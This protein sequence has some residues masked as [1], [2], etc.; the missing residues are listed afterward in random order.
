MPQTNTPTVSRSAFSGICT[1]AVVG[2]LIG[3]SLSGTEPGFRDLG[4]N[5]AHQRHAVRHITQTMARAVRTL[6]GDQTKPALSALPVGRPGR[7]DRGLVGIPANGRH[8]APPRSNVR[9][10]LL[11]L[12]P[13]AVR[14]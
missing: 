11:N 1:L 4:Q 5:A 14:A 12:P 6:V 7:A 8:E 2:L 9:L 3:A 13:P 10:A